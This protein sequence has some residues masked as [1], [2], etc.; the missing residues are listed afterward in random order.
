MV[1]Q[2]ENIQMYWKAVCLISDV[3]E[4]GTTAYLFNGFV[5]PFLR[6]NRY[7]SLVGAVYFAVMLVLYFIPWEMG[8]W[9]AYA[10]GG[11]TAFV[12]MYLIDRRNVEQKLFLSVT[13]YLL[14]WISRG[15]MLIFWDFLYQLL[16]MTP[17]MYQRPV[18]QL[19]CYAAVQTVGVTLNFFILKLFFGLIGR[20]YA[21]KEENM[22]KRELALMLGPSMSVLV[23]YWVF[24]FYENAYERNFK[25]YLS[26]VYPAYD[27]L[28]AL[29]QIVS[30]GA[31]FTVIV[32]YQSI[33]KSQREEREAAMLSEQIKD[34]KRHIREVETLYHDM[35][36]LKHDMGNHVMVL[37]HLC[38]KNEQEEAVKYLARLK[39]QFHEN[40]PELRSG[41]PVTD[42]ILTEKKREA[43]GK[44]IAFL[45]DFHYP[46]GTK[47]NA[48]DVSVILNNAA[49]NAIEAAMECA[50]S[51]VHISSYRRKNAY[52]I[53]IENSFS[54]ELILNA[55][56]GLPVSTKKEG[57]EHGFGF[58]NIRKVAQKYF[59]DLAIE[60]E[61]DKFTLSIML[62]VE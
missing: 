51:Y 7:H 35:R 11:V 44:G 2:M 32:I 8:G 61:E 14:R 19:L 22:T 49:A 62:M 38:V 48:F 52:V 16:I 46:E 1:G 17:A 56:S 47:L 5:T 53:E 13:F 15:I 58:F 30:F 20:V 10:F 6:K 54:G 33:K 24:V 42:V 39:A 37:E 4:I 50:D 25:L 31:L 9:C 41:N 3:I 27:W 60:Q 26:D 55:E 21:C 23:G 12:V 40:L 45:C 36:G 59:G 57:G 29:Y 43:E 34:M 18:L 28:K